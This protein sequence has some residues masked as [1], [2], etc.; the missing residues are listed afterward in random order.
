MG[1]SVFHVAAGART[2]ERSCGKAGPLGIFVAPGAVGL[3]IGMLWPGLRLLFSVMAVIVAAV[4]IPVSR[5]AQAD[6]R[7]SDVPR[8]PVADILLLTAAVAV[9]A[10][11][12]SVVHF[13]WQTTAALSLLT[14]AFVFAGKAL[15]G[16]LCDRLG[17][18]K[19]A[20]FSIFPAGL[21]IAFGSGIMI[22]SL[23]GQF[24]LNLTMPVTLWLLYRAMPDSP[25]FAF[26]IAASALWPGTIAGRL[27]R[28][29]GPIQW[30][31][32]LVCFLFGLWAIIITAKR[33]PDNLPR[34]ASREHL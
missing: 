10:V 7:A 27:I 9:R 34:S 14:V 24:A 5:G 8:L 1:N 20:L 17:P 18:V 12:G 21:L 16:I 19:S 25:G 2:L 3:A 11:G 29:T 32:V 23:L 31:F 22:P 33:K 6:V 13:A 30:I 15:G 28:L 4:L 26:G